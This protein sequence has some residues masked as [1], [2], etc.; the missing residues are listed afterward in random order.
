MKPRHTPRPRGHVRVTGKIEVNLDC[1]GGSRPTPR[2]PMEHQFCRIP[3]IQRRDLIGNQNFLRKSYGKNFCANGCAAHRVVAAMETLCDR[4]VAND[5]AG[6]Q[7]WKQR[8][9]EGNRDRIAFSAEATAV[10][11]DEI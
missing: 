1:V 4:F 8:Y 2:L 10:D 5:R 6:H 11:V 3:P 9:V 7:L